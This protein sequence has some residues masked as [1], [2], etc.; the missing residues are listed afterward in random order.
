MFYLILGFWT[1]FMGVVFSFST[2]DQN[3]LDKVG[4]RC[5]ANGGLEK[6]I[7]KTI[8]PV[9]LMCKDG[10]RFELKEEK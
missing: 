4:L 3:I 2:A 10:A 6:A 1:F 5:Q 8:G 7:F 9:E